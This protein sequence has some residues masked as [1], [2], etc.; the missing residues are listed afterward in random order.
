MDKSSLETLISSLEFWSWVFGVIVVIGVGGESVFGIR[1]I[2]NNRKLHRLEERENRVQQEEIA[3]LKYETAQL[4]ADSLALVKAS[5]DRGL[6]IL[7]N[8]DSPFWQLKKFAGI[9]LF[10]QSSA[11]EEPRNFARS[12]GGLEQLGFV[13]KW[14][15]ESQTGTT[16]VEGTTLLTWLPE[17]MTP[18]NDSAPRPLD[19]EPKTPTEKA[20]AAAEELTS[21][22]RLTG[23]DCQHF[24]FPRDL[25]PNAPITLLRFS[26]LPDGAILIT[27]GRRST[28]ELTVKY[29]RDLMGRLGKGSG[30]A[31]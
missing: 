15:D 19:H 14:T 30:Q 29:A 20:Y 26:T 18:K 31:R 25:S 5:R 1:L 21:Y 23:V 16:N 7:G 27:I 4:N 11:Q 9:E 2:W 8:Q 22:L 12:L 17:G 10:I 24:A 13:L 28:L 6:M 3:R